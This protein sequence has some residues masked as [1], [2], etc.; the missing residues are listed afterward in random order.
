MCADI[1]DAFAGDWLDNVY[2]KN[3]VLLGEEQTVLL[4]NN[5]TCVMKHVFLDVPPRRNNITTY[6]EQSMFSNDHRDRFAF[7]ESYSDTLQTGVQLVVVSCELIRDSARH[8]VVLIPYT[9][10]F[11]FVLAT[12]TG[13]AGIDIMECHPGY[14]MLRVDTRGCLSTRYNAPALPSTPRNMLVYQKTALSMTGLFASHST[15]GGISE[16]QPTPPLRVTKQIRHI[17]AVGIRY[18]MEIDCKNGDYGKCS[19]AEIV[20]Y[21]ELVA[22]GLKVAMGE[23]DDMFEVDASST[24]ATKLRF[25]VFRMANAPPSTWQQEWMS[26]NRKCPRNTQPSLDTNTFR[27]EGQVVLKMPCVLCGINTYYTERSMPLDTMHMKMVQHMSILAV[28][29]YYDIIPTPNVAPLRSKRYFL[30]SLPSTGY[31][32]VS[33]ESRL[34]DT[35]VGVGS[36]LH[37][38]LTAQVQSDEVTPATKPSA[39]VKVVCEGDNIMFAWGN[40][41][42]TSIV[43]QVLPEF[44]GKIIEVH[45]H[46]PDSGFPGALGGWLVLPALVFVRGPEIVQVCQWCP[47]GKFSGTYGTSSAAKCL[48]TAYTTSV[49]AYARRGLEVPEPPPASF[50]RGVLTSQKYQ[51]EMPFQ[52]F[53]S[54]GD[55][56]YTNVMRILQIPVVALMEFKLRVDL[57]TNAVDQ[58]RAHILDITRQVLALF[59]HR[60]NSTLTIKWTWDDYSRTELSVPRDTTIVVQW[61][62]AHPF[63]ITDK[64]LWGG[65][66]AVGISLSYNTE[67]NTTTFLVPGEFTGKLFYYCR[68]HE[69]MGIHEIKL[70]QREPLHDDMKSTKSQVFLSGA[71]NA[72]TTLIIHGM[73]RLNPAFYHADSDGGDGDNHNIRNSYDEV[74]RFNPTVRPELVNTTGCTDI[75]DMVRGHRDAEFPDTILLDAELFILQG[76]NMVSHMYLDPW[77][78][79]HDDESGYAAGMAGNMLE[80]DELDVWEWSLQMAKHIPGNVQV[81]VV[82]CLQHNGS[83]ARHDMPYKQGEF[84][85]LLRA[86]T[87][88]TEITFLGCFEDGL[89]C[90]IAIHSQRCLSSERVDL[91]APLF[92]QNTYE[93]MYE[94]VGDLPISATT[95]AFMHTRDTNISFSEDTSPGQYFKDF[96]FESTNT[97][98]QFISCR[99]THDIKC[100]DEQFLH[101]MS[102]LLQNL[103]HRSRTMQVF[104]G[105]RIFYTMARPQGP[106]NSAVYLRAWDFTSYSPTVQEYL[107]GNDA[108][109]SH[110]QTTGSIDIFRR[111][112]TV[113]RV[114]CLFCTLNTYS[115]PTVTPARIV[116]ETRELL[117]STYSFAATTQSGTTVD[118]I[119]HFVTSDRSKVITG[120]AQLHTEESVVDIGTTL[121][122][123]RE[124]NPGNTTTVRVLC[125]GVDVTTASINETMLSLYIRSEYSGRAIFVHIIDTSLPIGT[126]VQ[127]AVLFPRAAVTKRRCVSCP[128]GKF[129][130]MPGGTSL[131]DCVDT[132]APEILHLYSMEPDQTSVPNTNDSSVTPGPVMPQNVG[133]GGHMLPVVTYFE[134]AGGIV[135]VLS[136]EPTTKMH[137]TSQFALRAWLGNC[138]VEHVLNHSETVQAKLMH[139]YHGNDPSWKNAKYVTTNSILERQIEHLHFVQVTIE[140]NYSVATTTTTPMPEDT[141]TVGNSTTP[142]PEDTET[143]DP[144]RTTLA[145]SQGG[146]ETSA[147]PSTTPVPQGDFATNTTSPM[148]GDTKTVDTI[149][150]TLA[151][152]RGGSESTSLPSSTPVPQSDFAVTMAVSMPML[153]SEFDDSKQV[154][155]KNSVAA[156]A[157]VP[158]SD[159]TIAKIQDIAGTVV[160]TRRRLLSGGIRVDLSINA[161]TRSAA[162]Q[163]VTQLSNPTTLNVQLQLAGLPSVTMLQVPTTI[164]SGTPSVTP[165]EKDDN[166]P[167]SYVIGAAVGG[168]SLVVIFI[169]VL[170]WILQN[171]PVTGPS[172]GRQV[173]MAP[174]MV[175]PVHHQQAYYPLHPNKK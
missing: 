2:A 93:T 140:G 160:T 98:E 26:R 90:T 14:C 144:I 19:P 47:R 10:D 169:I 165:T 91:M 86:D 139:I 28:Y 128:A 87:G 34:L 104:D 42:K 100:S 172:Y 22:T 12:R 156:A 103:Q 107:G 36:T 70:L 79:R 30:S 16:V 11:S 92:T 141:K 118:H 88:D 46:D 149:R 52:T 1:A 102:V 127:P 3:V 175:A 109:G 95:A 105:S 84:N 31:G 8:A 49:A 147:L 15:M 153:L 37:L 126:I 32:A 119:A 123:H 17:T 166:M 155:F 151:T 134:V 38:Q 67:R 148:P 18:V 130:G 35:S 117:L 162:T 150:T 164:A 111:G 167:H 120:T 161:A 51:H 9:T 24:T 154:L 6:Y 129:Y 13:L 106:E 76:T 60:Q 133:N 25:N 135:T 112:A 152:S 80:G 57:N 171:R 72:V 116:D 170:L 122:L 131:A 29:D 45:I 138:F 163:V 39:I 173:P 101:C 4:E 121:L 75:A 85:V 158:S 113:G 125:D 65:S 132:G 44:A 20:E 58:V 66:D 21:T 83:I 59:E 142:V 48:D 137:A 99:N 64:L 115:S 43:L 174:V 168:V 50:V 62:P 74:V 108:C 68:Y 82:T 69:N 27:T 23:S 94:D 146:S 81:V 7:W 41:S 124:I 136:L 5:E 33:D 40:A 97:I 110:M 159:V 143:V 71:S 89:F 77:V 56:V 145:T 78:R 61:D 54:V 114:S 96:L 73:Y 157:A 55:G 53:L 63:H